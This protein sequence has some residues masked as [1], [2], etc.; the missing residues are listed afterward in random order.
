VESYFIDVGQGSC[1]VI[2][3]GGRRAI[4]VD[5]GRRSQEVL[6]ILSAHC[7]DYLECLA[8]SHNDA[9]HAGAA[10][11][12]LTQYRR[13]IGRIG[14]V[15]DN[16]LFNT[17]FWEK[18]VE[19]LRSGA[20]TKEQLFRL[21]R[22]DQPRFLFEDSQIG[23]SLKIL[24]PSTAENV[25]SDFSA[26]ANDT[27]AVLVL[28]FGKARIVYSGDASVEEWDS[29]RDARRGR[30]LACD[31]LA[32]P[33]HGG[34][35]HRK[36]SEL[37]RLYR[38]CVRPR[39]AVVSVGTG[40]PYNHPRQDV[41]RLLTAGGCTTL[42]TQITTKCCLD[43]ERFRAEGLPKV[44]AGRS[45]TSSDLTREGKSRN[46]ACAGTI[47]IVFNP[48]GI[49]ID[50]LLEHQMLLDRWF[51]NSPSP[52]CRRFPLT[53]ITLPENAPSSSPSVAEPFLNR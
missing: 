39:Y 11:A 20:L 35:V 48:G 27:S 4:V 2:L 44:F 9:D 26:R 15:K 21:E 37:N 33:H 45:F 5:C 7:V 18:I 3:L 43:L 34:A 40:N 47:H 32:V 50:R 16:K 12:V 25:L 30:P 51:G 52:L 6:G 31:I 46:V 10:A 36:G 38:D 53:A 49:V 19:D 23:L 29:I 42:C 13:A 17:A 41:L 28:T 14:F 24:A 8:V 1:N 22:E